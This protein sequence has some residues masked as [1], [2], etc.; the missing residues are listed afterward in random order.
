MYICLLLTSGDDRLLV[1]QQDL[2]LPILE[3]GEDFN[4]TASMQ[5]D[6]AWII[7]V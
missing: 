2:N 3:I 6:Y 4:I 1:T 7:R 5:S